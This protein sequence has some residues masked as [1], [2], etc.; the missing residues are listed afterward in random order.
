MYACVGSE[1]LTEVI[2]KNSVVSDM[3]PCSLLKSTDVPEE[4]IAFFRAEE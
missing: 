3:G 2:M 4:Y 1:V